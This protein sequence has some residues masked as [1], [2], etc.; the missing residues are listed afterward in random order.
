MTDILLVNVPHSFL[1][2]HKSEPAVTSQEGELFSYPPL[3][4]L[5]LASVLRTRHY[6]VTVIDAPSKLFSIYD[7]TYLVD[8]YDPSILGLSVTTPQVR[9]AVQLGRAVKE[10]RPQTKIVLGGSHAT[11]DPD[12]MIKYPYFDVQFQGEGEVT[13]PHI[14]S[15][16]E[17]GKF[18]G[19]LIKGEEVKDLDSLPFPS[20]D[21]IDTNA[22]FVPIYGERFTSMLS[23]RGCPYQ[24]SFC[25][26]PCVPKSIRFRSP[27]N[28]FSEMRE[29][30]E[31]YSI[32]HFQF[33]DDIFGVDRRRTLDL[34]NLI[35]HLD[36]QFGFQTRVELMQDE[37]YVWA[38][39]EAG[40]KEI[41]LGIE[42]GDEQIRRINGKYFSDEA[43]RRT[44]KLCHQHNIEINGFYIIGLIGDNK[45]TIAKT[46]RHPSMIGVDYVE[47]QVI[48]P[49]PGTQVFEEGIR[50]T[51]LN[52][53]VWDRFAS[54][55]LEEQPVYIPK[56]LTRDYMLQAQKHAYRIFYFNPH[57]VLKR[58]SRDIT[59]V[60]KLRQ[61]A[62]T[63]I[64]LAK[65]FL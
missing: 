38:L 25:S 31:Q 48:V 18:D 22:Y 56:T 55:E 40:C 59:S 3:G 34:L 64:V 36:I 12:F 62:K 21:L 42:S 53:E 32:R 58:F 46:V 7:L 57:Y 44:V 19:Q 28:I 6:S 61:D 17:A 9:S 37:N 41:S 35:K 15:D 14:V 33:V 5:Y 51:A 39:A 2:T 52:G 27:Q 16:I 45:D 65:S 11:L 1:G 54:G 10:Q 24:C 4:I 20:R 50:E 30:K 60:K 43:L 23:S 47:F 13:F 8:S 29:C 26:R 63:A 49:Y